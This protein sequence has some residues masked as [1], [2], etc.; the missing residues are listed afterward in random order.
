V[1]VDFDYLPAIG[2]R[3]RRTVRSLRHKQNPAKVK[4]A[5][6][7]LTRLGKKT[8][9]GLLQRVYLDECGFSP[10]PLWPG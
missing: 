1:V 3:W 8:A 2:A 5:K 9:A 4:R 6:A 10:P 7:H